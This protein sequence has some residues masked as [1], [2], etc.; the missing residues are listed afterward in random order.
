MAAEP[1]QHVEQHHGTTPQG[2]SSAHDKKAPSSSEQI[3]T[4]VFSSL[5]ASEQWLLNLGS[6]LSGI[7]D[8]AS[9]DTVRRC[10]GPL[11]IACLAALLAL[12]VGLLLLVWKVRC[13]SN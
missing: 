7:M 6:M 13:K 5:Q 3:E 10:A 9:A 2:P 8:H 12:T 1:R 11:I 4:A